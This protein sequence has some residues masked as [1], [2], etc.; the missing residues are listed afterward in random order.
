MREERSAPDFNALF[1]VLNSQ[2]GYFDVSQAH[3]AG[4]SDQLLQHHVRSGRFQR[5]LRGV[6]RLVHYPSTEH[7]ELVSL[8]LWSQRQG[9]FS[10]RTAL[11]L[12]GIGEELPTC[13]ELTLP[14]SWQRRRLRVPE[15]LRL[16]YADVPHEERMWL[17]SLPLTRPARSLLDALSYL[18]PDRAQLAIHDT[19]NHPLLTSQRRALLNRAL[20]QISP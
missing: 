20:S 8:W 10:H 18:S 12:L 13:V 17:G 14:L 16:Y 3:E 1:E 4:Y 15:G 11:G 6:Y 9:V 5:A 7:E 2:Q 19:L